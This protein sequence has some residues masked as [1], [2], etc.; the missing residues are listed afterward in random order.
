MSDPLRI[1]WVAAPTEDC[2]SWGPW[3]PT[4]PIPARQAYQL[5]RRSR[6]IWH[7]HLF[8]VTPPDR[9]PLEPRP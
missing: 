6:T 5:A 8:A 2:L 3:Q 9:R 7:G 4:D 1:V